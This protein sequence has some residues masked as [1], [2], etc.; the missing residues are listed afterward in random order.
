LTEHFVVDL[1]VR[2]GFD[3]S[4][5]QDIMAIWT[6]AA[7]FPSPLNIVLLTALVAFIVIIGP[8]IEEFV[9]RHLLHGCLEG[10]T[11]NPVLRVLANGVIFG[12]AHLS[13]A[14]GWK[15]VPIFLVTGLLGIVNS[16]LREATGD[17]VSSSTAH[18]LHNGTVMG[19]FLLK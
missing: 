9:F 8:I 17:I 15:N 5:A 3:L 7:C 4:P 10:I 19:F 12:A 11:D 6:A 13:S 16:A 1:M 2:W 14:Q 18:I